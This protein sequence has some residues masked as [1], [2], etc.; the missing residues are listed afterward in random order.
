MSAALQSEPGRPAPTDRAGLA[1]TTAKSERVTLGAASMSGELCTVG[2][3]KGL[4]LLAH[5]G[6]GGQGASGNRYL[7]ELLH[8]CGIGTLSFNLLTEEELANDRCSL[9]IALQAWRIGQAVLWA[10]R[11]RPLPGG[12][13]GLAASGTGTAAA[14]ELAVA[15]PG[16]VAS[17]VS[18]SGRPDLAWQNLPRV[19][20]PTLLMVGDREPSVTNLNRSA[21]RELQ[22]VKRLEVIPGA[23]DL[24]AESGADEGAAALAAQWLQENL[25]HR[26]GW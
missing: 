21:L 4:V 3:M 13:Y 15:M 6:A 1:A 11:C 14:L 19:R 2:Q 20:A 8:R 9:D 7:A 17:I 16:S 24:A 12:P 5:V 22:C 10:G 18:R 23:A 26:R 25:R